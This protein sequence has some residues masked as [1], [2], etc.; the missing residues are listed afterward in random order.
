MPSHVSAS[1]RQVKENGKQKKKNRNGRD[2]WPET[3][4]DEP[5]DDG[6]PI[7]GEERTVISQQ[8]RPLV[9]QED[10]ANLQGAFGPCI[11]KLNDAKS[12]IMHS[13]ETIDDLMKHIEN[14]FRGSMHIIREL[15]DTWEQGDQKA[16]RILKLEAQIT[17]LMHWQDNQTKPLEAKLNIERERNEALISEKEALE[18]EYEMQYKDREMQLR[19]REEAL[20]R[21][22]SVL[23]KELKAQKETLEKSFRT[24]YD[25]AVE[26]LALK[27]SSLEN[28]HGSLQKEFES[29]SSRFEKSE[30]AYDNL[31]SENNSLKSQVEVFKT[32]FGAP[33]EPDDYL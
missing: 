7:Q 21:E 15:G 26:K 22:R 24:Q 30:R 29:L 16:E 8:T 31:N 32:E 4:E 11:E 17:E 12:K 28:N 20:V 27:Y 3:D 23:E 9:S 2:Y 33:E 13:A 10:I 1:S 19:E 6:S 14:S 25:K 18:A 5:Q